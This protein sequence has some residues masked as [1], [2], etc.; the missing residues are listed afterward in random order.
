MEEALRSAATPLVVA[1]LP[2]APDLTASRRLQLAAGTGGGRGL[3][4]IPEGRLCNNAAET[5]WMCMPM[6]GLG[7]GGQHWEALKNKRGR[8]VTWRAR[9]VDGRFVA[10][11]ATAA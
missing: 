2:Q 1:E 4:L 6:P 9:C 5:R 7:S 10:E 11:E 8:L 3:C